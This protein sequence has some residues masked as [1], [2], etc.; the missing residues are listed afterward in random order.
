MT[1][2]QIILEVQFFLLFIA[3]S[4][5]F[6]TLLLMPPANDHQEYNYSQSWIYGL[7]TM[8]GNVHDGEPQGISIMES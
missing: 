1:Y 7:A 5:N 6:F 3:T 2:M 4:L 8:R